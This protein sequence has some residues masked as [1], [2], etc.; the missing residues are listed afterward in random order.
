MRYSC[1]ILL[2]NPHRLRLYFAKTKVLS[3]NLFNKKNFTWIFIGYY[4]AISFYI[5]KFALIFYFL[6]IH[7]MFSGLFM[8]C[9][10]NLA[11]S[12]I[13]IIPGNLGIKEA[14]F[15]GFLHLYG[16]DFSVALNLAII[17]RIFQIA[18]LSFGAIL[19]LRSTNLSHLKVSFG[20]KDNVLKVVC[21]SE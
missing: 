13:P 14:S 9:V 21:S 8:A 7:I 1:G 16:V 15:A 10:L 17:D 11:I 12:L 3:I 4:F 19:F 5:L 20:K 2:I 6:D 18:F